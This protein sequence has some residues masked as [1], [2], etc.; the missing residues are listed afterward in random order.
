MTSMFRG[1]DRFVVMRTAT[2]TLGIINFLKYS[3]GNINENNYKVR[4]LVEII[5]TY[6]ILRIFLYATNV[7]ICTVCIIQRTYER[8][9]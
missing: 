3:F 5:I 1:I 8:I 4:V 6:Y 7:N 2:V 9:N